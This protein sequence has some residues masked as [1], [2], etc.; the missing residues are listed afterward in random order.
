MMNSFD[1]RV[2]SLWSATVDLQ[3]QFTPPITL[4]LVNSESSPNF[5]SNIKRIE[6]N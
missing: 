4:K 1:K 2:A 5:A 3:A 6:A